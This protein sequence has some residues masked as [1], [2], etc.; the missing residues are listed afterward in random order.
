MLLMDVYRLLPAMASILQATRIAADVWCRDDG[1]I[2]T[3][4]AG[5]GLAL[6]ARHPDGSCNRAKQNKS[7]VENWFGFVFIMPLFRR[8]LLLT[9][10]G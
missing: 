1:E 2:L 3:G 7:I 4:R 9:I 5:I 10:N 6:V 8:N